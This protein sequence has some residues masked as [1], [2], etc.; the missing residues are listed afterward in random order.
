MNK[1]EFVE[2]KKKLEQEIASNAFQLILFLAKKI[3][4]KITS[5]IA[6]KRATSGYVERFLSEYGN[7]K[8]IGMTSPL[9][10]LNIFTSVRILDAGQ[11]KSFSTI[12]DLEENFKRSKERT[13]FVYNGNIKKGFEVA[14]QVQ[15]LNVLGA[16]GSGKSTFLK[17]IAIEALTNSFETEKYLT[18]NKKEN[19]TAE[20][21]HKLRCKT[22]VFKRL[23]VFIELKKVN[24]KDIDIFSIVVDELASCGFAEA[25]DFTKKM[26]DSGHFLILLDGLDEVAQEVLDKT[27]RKIHTFVAKYNKN[28][29]ITS[30]RTAFYK[31]YF[32]KFTDVVLSDFNV[33]QISEF[34]W[35][36]FYARNSVGAKYLHKKFLH[37]LN[38][39]YNKAIFE[40]AR[41]PLL[42]TFLCLAFDV[43]QKFP[44]NRSSLYRK[45]LHILLEEWAAE[46]RVHNEDI[47]KNLHPE[48]EIALLSSIAAP[49]FIN[50]KLFFSKPELL[51]QISEFME[52]QVQAPKNLNTGCILDAI[53]IQQGLLVQ[54]ANDIYS[55]S[56]LT[57]QEFLT[58]L[59][60][61]ENSDLF[62]DMIGKHLFDPRWREFFLL[63]A[64]FGK[65]TDTLGKMADTLNKFISS[66]ERLNQIRI[67]CNTFEDKK[68]TDKQNI[69]WKLY[70]L[71]VVSLLYLLRA[72]RH[73][74]INKFNILGVA[75][76][77][78]DFDYTFLDDLKTAITIIERNISKKIIQDEP[79]ERSWIKYNINI[80][81]AHIYNEVRMKFIEK[82]NI[83]QSWRK[84]N[85]TE[86][87]DLAQYIYCI[88]L[89]ND[90]RK[91][92]LILSKKDW[93]KIALN[94]I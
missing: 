93:Q 21:K 58:S 45:A 82:C 90:C 42:L 79:E 4:I 27:I 12:E 32:E 18:I 63:H 28:R 29:F 75:K 2:G 17:R 67:W 47:Y 50:S 10:I 3:K 84:L 49:A 19:L 13:L 76:M 40:L 23:P 44:V 1:I 88:C 39:P 30:C 73:F 26:L 43:T 54:R 89:I 66:K 81:E 78:L 80:N 59:Y 24:E 77:C 65:A 69:A 68:R 87:S 20:D 11:L 85:E 46:K 57:I 51:R 25:E 33:D 34:S 55:F 48:L 7:I 64:G 71:V 38:E 9:P 15:F 72:D 74:S 22:Y 83:D 8:V 56:H 60:F 92:A 61:Y 86:Y 62:P 94:L 91:S 14:N 36:W 53:E 31:T 5:A 41:S 6:L 70:A 37:E 52:D 35:N 16:P